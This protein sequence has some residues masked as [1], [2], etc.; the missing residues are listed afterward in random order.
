ME[1]KSEIYKGK[2]DK[3]KT[4]IQNTYYYHNNSDDINTEE[5]TNSNE[6]NEI[7]K[8]D[9]LKKIDNIFKRNDYVYQASIN[10]M[11]KNGKNIEEKIVGRKN[12]YL[13]TIDGKTIIIDDIYDIN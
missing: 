5:N 10:I 8:Y 13:L 3:L 12:N 6:K 1:K 4:N 9:L 7:S 11:Y 2:L